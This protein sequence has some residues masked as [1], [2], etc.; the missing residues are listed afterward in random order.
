MRVV[1]FAGHPG[2]LRMTHSASLLSMLN[3]FVR[4][5][6]TVLKHMIVLF[7]AFLLNLCDCKDHVGCAVATVKF[8]LGLRESLLCN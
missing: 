7:S 8:T 5:M 1:N 2:F 6:K 3:A 4:S